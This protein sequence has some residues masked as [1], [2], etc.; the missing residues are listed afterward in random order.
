MESDINSI[1]SSHN[2]N[3]E[4]NDKINT[5]SL[6]ISEA[7]TINSDTQNSK[8]SEIQNSK[9][10][11]SKNS[12]SIKS[13]LNKR[14]F[15][16]NLKT[17][18][19]NI[20]KVLNKEESEKKKEDQKILIEKFNKVNESQIS[21]DTSSIKI[22][23]SQK[24]K[25]K[26]KFKLSLYTLEKKSNLGSGAS[27]DVYLVEDTQTHK[28][29]ALKTVKYTDEKKVE[30]QLETEVKLSSLLKHEN[31][32]RCYATYFLEG[33]INFVMEY[34]DKGT[35]ADLIKKVKKIPENII[36]IIT[37]QVVKGLAYIQKDKRIIHRDLKPSNILINSKGYA[38]ISDFGVSAMVEGSWAQKKTM[39]GTYIYMAPERID[40]DIYYLNCDVWSLGIIVMECVLGYY[41]YL[42]YNNFEPL[43]SVWSLHELI[44]NNPVPPLDDKVYSKELIDFLKKCLIKDLKVRPTANML[45]QHP[46]IVKYQDKSR[47]ELAIWLNSIK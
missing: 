34:M 8:N 20:S 12:S 23:P 41:P 6:H 25:E 17:P 16:I 14:K 19:L 3:N 5:N 11:D 26:K 35:L 29:L 21:Y 36:G 28:K 32:I 47:E 46:F 22:E 31:I 7:S 39:V 15:H 30:Q 4:I 43:N 9:N 40:A 37:Y 27:G 10:S 18:K 45:L 42:I 44:E 1:S 2:S 33:T 38:K 24:I 13:N